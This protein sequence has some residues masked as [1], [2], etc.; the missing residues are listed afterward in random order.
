MSVVLGFML[1][2]SPCLLLLD[3]RRNKMEER[4]RALPEPQ[5]LGRERLK[6]GKENGERKNL[7]SYD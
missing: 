6:G 3:E 4:W 5:N 7:S 1:P 2:A